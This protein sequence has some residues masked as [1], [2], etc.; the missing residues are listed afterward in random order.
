MAV[1]ILKLCFKALVKLRRPKQKSPH[2]GLLANYLQQLNGLFFKK[3]RRVMVGLNVSAGLVR[4]LEMCRKHCRR[5][6][7]Y[8][9]EIAEGHNP[10]LK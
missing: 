10:P 5:Q 4:L 3:Q 2:S 8:F 9:I 7:L 6:L 1:A